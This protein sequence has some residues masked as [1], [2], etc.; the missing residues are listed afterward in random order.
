MEKNIMKLFN[1]Q[2]LPGVI[3]LL[4]IMGMGA[5]LIAQYGFGLQP[6][7]YCILQR[8]VLL[9]LIIN[10]S[11]FY[12]GQS[13]CLSEKFKKYNS[14]SYFYF[15]MLILIFALFTIVYQYFIASHSFSCE[16]TWADQILQKT[17]LMDMMPSVFEPRASCAEAKFYIIGISFEIYVFIFLMILSA[18]SIKGLFSIKQK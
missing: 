14:Y 15:N 7:P 11:F 12:I 18:L 1:Q 4:A 9:G 13:S 3:G 8:V 10:A 17:K 16:L 6:C 5:A 2:V